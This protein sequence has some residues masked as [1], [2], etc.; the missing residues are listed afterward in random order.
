MISLVNAPSIFYWEWFWKIG[1]VANISCPGIYNI[2]IFN[3]HV[4]IY[5]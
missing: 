2:Y 5:V 1:L 4:F 3:M